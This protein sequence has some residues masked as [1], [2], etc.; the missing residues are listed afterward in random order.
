M[1]IVFFI[2]SLRSLEEFR[3][4]PHAQI[5]PKLLVQF[6]KALAKN[7]KFNLNLKEFLPWNPAQ[8]A[9]RPVRPLWPSRPT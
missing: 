1:H 8:S 7:L 5:P 3:K 4:N 2:K 6:S 9:S